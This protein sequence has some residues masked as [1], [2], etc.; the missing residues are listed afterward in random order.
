MRQI[1]ISCQPVPLKCA[2]G[3][4]A[5]RLEGRIEWRGQLNVH[6]CTISLIREILVGLVSTPHSST[7]NV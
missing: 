1:Y 3:H 4:K 7:L 6:V 2:L 5:Q